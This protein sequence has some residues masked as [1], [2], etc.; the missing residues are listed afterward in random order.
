[1]PVFSARVANSRSPRSRG[2]I[3]CAALA[4]I[5]SLASSG[6]AVAAEAAGTVAFQ[7]FGG[8]LVQDIGPAAGPYPRYVN[9]VVSGLPS[10]WATASGKCLSIDRFSYPQLR[11]TYWDGVRGTKTLEAQGYR[12]ATPQT[13]A[14]YGFGADAFSLCRDIS[15]AVTGFTAQVTLYVPQPHGGA[16]CGV[17][18]S[19]SGSLS[20]CSSSSL[21]FY[22]VTA[23]AVSSRPSRITRLR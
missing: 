18:A 17:T 9:I 12:P 23:R 2:R 3:C 19:A 10:A 8:H 20:Q 14:L 15:G 6:G 4:L 13:G 7:I 5:A 11:M 22:S 1:M 21:Q 16:S